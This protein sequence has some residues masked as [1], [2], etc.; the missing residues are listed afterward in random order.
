[1]P[2]EVKT[3]WRGKVGGMTE[4]E[5]DTFLQYGVTMHLACVKPDGSPYMTVCWHEWRDGSFWVVPRQRSEWARHL[6]NDP[7]VS[8]VVDHDTTLEKVWGEGLAELVEEP[9]VGGK[10]VE[11][12]ERMS[13]R[14]LGENGPTYLV[15]TMKQPRW[16]FRIT[17]T[18]IKTWQG[19]GW[20]RRYWVEETGGPSYE[21]AHAT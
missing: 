19:V 9:N 1:M 14:Y 12:A 8:F 18:T 7:R 4:E 6:K 2:D 21:E 10:W 11:V 15:P 17:P 3:S 20:A 5:M 16:L 13:V